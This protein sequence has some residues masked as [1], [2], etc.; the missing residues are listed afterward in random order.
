[1]TERTAPRL[2]DCSKARQGE[3][4]RDSVKRARDLLLPSP[5]MTASL[6]DALDHLPADVQAL[7]A[8]HRFDRARFSRLAE[9]VRAG[10]AAS[11]RVGGT[12]APPA[13]GD[14]TDLPPPGSDERQRLEQLG[15]DALS[16][17]EC[18][19]VVLAGGMATRMGGVVKALVDAVPGHSFL[20]LRLAE[21]AHLEQL[22]GRAPPFWL[23]TSD[24]TDGPIRAALGQRLDGERIATFT[25]GRSLRLAPDGSLFL[26][27]DGRP[28]LHSPGHGDLPDALHDS[29]L[30]ARF[31]ERGGKL[32]TMANLDHLGGTLDPV[33]VG[34]HLAHGRPVS[35]E[36]VDKLPSDRGGIPVRWNDRPVVLEEFRLPEGFDP[37]CVP[38]FNT[39]T[40]HFT[41]RALLD[42]K[43][44]WTFFVAQKKVD[45][46]PVVQFERLIGEVTS[47]LDTRF[48]RLPRDGAQSRFLPVKDNDE[49]ERQRPAIE[50]CAR[51]RGMLR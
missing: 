15:L 17:G 11:N 24:S 27:A 44:E 12:V 5:A 48:V 26:G 29:G 18:A 6:S 25:Q 40:F 14:V 16:R 22:T 8:H 23:M 7:L 9:R 35:C 13:P 19:L 37:T 3:R 32:V 49:L 31:V 50:L 21:V 47:H 28:S 39:N 38:V 34:W 42:L 20:D 2:A 1:M 4:A 41:A 36:V 45:G 10:A 46:A 43:M 51:A 33:L 30:L